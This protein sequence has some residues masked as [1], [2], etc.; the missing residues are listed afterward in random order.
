MAPDL[1]SADHA[2]RFFG[3]I[4]LVTIEAMSRPLSANIYD[5]D[6]HAGEIML[7]G[8]VAS[9]TATVLEV[10]VLDCFM[11]HSVNDLNVLRR[12]RWT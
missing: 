10:Q 9:Y 12:S 11:L 7:P 1:G 8:S 5:S 4:T 2:R 3:T 6:L